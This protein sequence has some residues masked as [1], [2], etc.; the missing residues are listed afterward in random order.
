V[1]RVGCRQQVVTSDDVVFDVSPVTPIPES[2]V[3]A[4]VCTLSRSACVDRVGDIRHD[5][6]DDDDG[7]AAAAL[8]GHSAV[9]L[10]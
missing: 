1:C 9:A 6:D 4:P 5:D 10:I 2:R 8:S 3:A 7:A